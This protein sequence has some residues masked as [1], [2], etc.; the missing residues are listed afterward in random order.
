MHTLLYICRTIFL[1]AAYYFI[2]K[3]NNTLIKQNYKEN[4]LL[5][6]SFL[7]NFATL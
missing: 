7:C 4:F 1:S 2:K 3:L 5:G 6:K